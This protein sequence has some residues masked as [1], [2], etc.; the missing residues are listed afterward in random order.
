MG[1]IHVV[2][3][4]DTLSRIAS[5]N[6]LPNW[7]VIYDHPRNATFRARRPDPN[8]IHPG[9]QI[10]IPIDGN[11]RPGAPPSTGQA[12]GAT[13]S[14]GTSVADEQARREALI[15]A[16][17]DPAAREPA[18]RAALRENELNYR[19]FHDPRYQL[20][21]GIRPP[22]VPPPGSFDEVRPGT[23]SDIVNATLAYPAVRRAVDQLREQ[24]IS[25]VRRNWDQL[26]G[27]DRAILITHT[28]V[29][30]AL[31]AAS[32]ASSDTTRQAAYNLIRDREINVPVPWMPGL[33]VQFTT[34][35]EHRV[36]L[37]IDIAELLKDP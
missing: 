8:L 22:S 25:Q 17:M 16:I 7:R 37:T 19:L 33:S 10:Y 31:G 12:A 30:G 20:S 14:N 9:D 36:G 29:I 21:R 5:S 24:A 27:G 6:G 3:R 4:G 15:R 32:I 23:I 18:I 34:G 2:Q 35:E 28:A 26:S 11:V 13:G 1:H